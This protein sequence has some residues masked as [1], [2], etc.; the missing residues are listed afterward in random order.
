MRRL[1][2]LLALASLL[3]VGVAP[4]L[5]HRSPTKKEHSAIDKAM[6]AYI[7]KKHSKAPSDAKIT[8]VVVST[9]NHSYALV[10]MSSKKAGKSRALVHTKKAKWTVIGY[11]VGGFSC[12][13]AP[14]KIFKDLLGGAGNC[15]AGGY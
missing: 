6:L 2:L 10:T 3:V 7:H 4:A 9:A 13:I 8:K 1:L 11:G 5:A 14:A 15:I 12:S